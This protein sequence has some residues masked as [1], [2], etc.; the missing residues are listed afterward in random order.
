MDSLNS[1]GWVVI[2]I[3]GGINGFI[4]AKLEKISHR[5]P[6]SFRNL[7][8]EIFGS[9]SGRQTYPGTIEETLEI[10]GKGPITQSQP[11]PIN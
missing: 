7:L 4:I 9:M 10:C 2:D 5:N 11:V 8:P 1:I 6:L 3:N